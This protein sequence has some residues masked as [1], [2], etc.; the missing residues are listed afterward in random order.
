M[1]PSLN[2]T[3][4]T[5]SLL[6]SFIAALLLASCEMR[7]QI[8]SSTNAPDIATYEFEATGE[9]FLISALDEVQAIADWSESFQNGLS[10]RLSELTSTD[11]KPLLMI[12]ST[13]TVYIYGQ[14][15]PGGYGAVVTERYARPKGLLLITVRKT[16]GKGN[17]HIVTE[18]KRYASYAD[19]RNDN[20]QQSNVAEMYGTQS[21]TIVTHVLRNGT[22]QTYTFRLPVVTRVVNPQDGSIRITSRYA[23]NGEIH[24]KT[25]DGDGNLVQLRRS[26]GQSDG[27]TVTRT[28]Y[29]D[30]SWRQVRTHGEADGTVTRETTS[31]LPTLG[32]GN[33]AS[34]QNLP[35]PV[36]S[37]WI[38]RGTCDNLH[39]TSPDQSRQDIPFLA[40]GTMLPIG[41]PPR[42]RFTYGDLMTTVSIASGDI[43][44]PKPPLPSL[45]SGATMIIPKPP[46]PVAGWDA[47]LR[48]GHFTGLGKLTDNFTNFASGIGT[49]PVPPRPA[50]PRETG[51]NLRQL[52]SGTLCPPTN[53]P[54]PAIACMAS[55]H[56][57][58]LAS[59]QSIPGP[60]P[61][62]TFPSRYPGIFDADHAFT[63]LASGNS[64]SPPVVPRPILALKIFGMSNAKDWSTITHTFQSAGYLLAS[65]ITTCPKPPIPVYASGATM[66]APKPPRPVVALLMLRSA[67]A[68]H[69]PA[70]VQA[71]ASSKSSL[72]SG[73]ATTLPPLPRPVAA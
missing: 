47:L 26:Y 55:T 61:R 32:S 34:P 53:I 33:T 62:P 10:P 16:Y 63:L 11:K 21:D 4:L 8:P 57:P 65:G 67:S 68:R 66:F 23:S 1:H 72:C 73:L 22:L 58:L 50:I 6:A 36:M 40:S 43:S 7:L 48:S 60:V 71:T 59:G 14:I 13:D 37:L 70:I 30:G 3:Q 49:C 17:G 24:S 20:P 28:E 44:N 2:R 45:A 51:P 5:L 64:V 42:P 69:R 19:H 52:A 12:T 9:D 15:I 46:L 18:T 39:G 35:R 41:T 56:A 38:P 31:G 29:T 54:R 25:T 27:S